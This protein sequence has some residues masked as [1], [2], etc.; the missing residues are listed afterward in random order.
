M[1]GLLGRQAYRLVLLPWLWLVAAAAMAEPYVASCG[2]HLQRLGGK[3]AALRFVG[4]SQQRE[5]QGA[6]YEAHYRVAGAAVPGVQAYLAARFAAP[7]LAFVCCGWE[8]PGTFYRDA[9]GYGHL[10]DFSSGET[11]ERDPA[12]WAKLE[13]FYLRVRLYAEDP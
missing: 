4:C 13:D 2:D 5:L 9:H 1:K 10:I 6:P 11:L 8:A 3:P 12:R 7:P